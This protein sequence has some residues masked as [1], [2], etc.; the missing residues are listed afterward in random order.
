MAERDREDRGGGQMN[1]ARLLAPA[2]LAAM[3]LTPFLPAGAARADVA[4]AAR[5]IDGDTIEVAGQR[6]RLYGI[7][8]PET[9]QNC[10]KRWRCGARASKALAARIGQR[11]VACKAKGRDRYKRLVAVCRAGGRDLGAWMVSQGWALAARNYSTAYVR[12]EEAAA[13]GARGIWRGLAEFEAPWDWR[14]RQRS[15]ASKPGDCGAWNTAG[16][17]Q[18]ATAKDVARCLA[19]GASVKVRGAGGATPLHSAATY[20][21]ADTVYVLLRARASVY[22]R[23]KGGETPLHAASSNSR[24]PN[25]IAALVERGAPV[26]AKDGSGSMPLHAAA[27]WGESSPVVLALVQAHG[28][29]GVALD[30]RNNAGETAAELILENE[31]LRDTPA[32]RALNPGDTGGHTE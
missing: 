32:A 26:G 2:A 30:I 18:Q 16:F 13:L 17:F 6:V 24:V 4:G 3:F 14:R 12:Q 25:V 5:V 27:E 11:R 10:G 7:D 23:D 9:R 21:T 31:D 19:K 8:A 1:A 29:A 22:V 15:S 20:G 28:D